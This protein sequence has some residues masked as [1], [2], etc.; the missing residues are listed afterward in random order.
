MVVRGQKK[1]DK[2][3]MYTLQEYYFLR[4]QRLKTQINQHRTKLDI[5]RPR[6]PTMR[7]YSMMRM[8][9]FLVLLVIEVMVGDSFY[10]YF[11]ESMTIG[12]FL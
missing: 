2:T 6:R 7:P 5:T 9:E 11:T 1:T 4:D 10:P 12:S 8:F 3:P